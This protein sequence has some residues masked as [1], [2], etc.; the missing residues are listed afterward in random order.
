[1]AAAPAV[2]ATI[3]ISSNESAVPHPD[4]SF[5]DGYAICA[6]PKPRKSLSA[7]PIGVTV[8]CPVNL[9]EPGMD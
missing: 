7:T 4:A 2:I 9:P 1:M 5:S 3:C 6:A 8:T